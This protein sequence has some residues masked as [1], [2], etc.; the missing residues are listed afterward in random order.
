MAARI[1]YLVMAIGAIMIGAGGLGI[2]AFLDVLGVS[3]MVL[4]AIGAAVAR[5]PVE[6]PRPA[7][8]PVR[9]GD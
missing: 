8:R 9:V 5:E 7:K 6:T 1:N 3:L 4:G 2:G